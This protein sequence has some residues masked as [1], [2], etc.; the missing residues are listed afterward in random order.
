MT[1]RAMAEPRKLLAGDSH[2]ELARRLAAD[3]D[4][5][6]VEVQVGTFADGETR[7]HISASVR[8]APVLVVQPTCPPVN[9]NL[10][11]L[12]FIADAAR[13][14]GA[15][16]IGAIVPY[17]GYARQDRRE[18]EGEPRSAQVA[19]RLLAAVGIDH[20]ITLDLH[21]PA[22]E[23]A[24]PIPLTH[25]RPE[26]VLLPLIESWN[27]ERLTVAAPDAGA[28]HR[29]QHYAK[30][31]GAE[32]AAIAK[33][34]VEVDR[35]QPLQVLGDVRGRTCLLLDDMAST[36][37]TLAAAAELLAE[38]GAKAVHAVFTHAVM[39]AGAL[40][41]LTESPLER[42]VMTNSIPPPVHPRIE[43]VHVEP[44]LAEI[45]RDL[46]PA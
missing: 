31:L 9:D 14:A 25:L 27:L 23:S 22:L 33:A 2:P 13:A 44:M 45:V 40:D 17:F 24:F 37:K 19:A 16:W 39:A 26:S 38:G 34:R 11:K 6:L 10:M 36:G 3:T 28:L 18:A 32:L 30:A 5:D 35:P 43:V 8:H 1:R 29:A 42:L 4:S 41:R 12:A 20:L 21:A 7:V 15:L 46:S